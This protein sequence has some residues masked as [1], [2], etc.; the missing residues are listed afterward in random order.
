MSAY[1]GNYHKPII[2]AASIQVFVAG[3]QPQ[4]NNQR[5]QGQR[6]CLDDQDVDLVSIDIAGH[7]VQSVIGGAS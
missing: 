4:A 7:V 5:H 2:N 1:Q 6:D 3:E